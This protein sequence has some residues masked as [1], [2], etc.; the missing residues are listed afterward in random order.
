MPFYI[1]VSPDK[2]YIQI[3]LCGII[4]AEDLPVMIDRCDNL[5][6]ETGITN[7]LCDC[8][9]MNAQHSIMD[10][11]DTIDNFA[12]TAN[13]TSF[14]EALVYNKG[15]E[16]EEK[17]RFYETAALNRGY[18]VRMFSDINEAIKWLYEFK[19]KTQ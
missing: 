4:K 11:Y 12:K 15:A 8:R 19:I 1:T 7:F 13:A 16:S 3:N 14:R 17:I 5:I 6:K 18:F 9:E 10:L 2:F